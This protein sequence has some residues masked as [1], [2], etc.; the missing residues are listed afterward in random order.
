MANRS[1]FMNDFDTCRFQR[2][3]VWLGAAS[4]G[5]DDLDSAL[6]DRCDVFRIR[7]RR[8]H[9]KKSQVHAEWSVSHVATAGNFLGQ[10]LG[11]VLRQPSDD[12]QTAGIGNRRCKFGKTD[13]VHAALD[14][15]MPY[16]E[17]FGNGCPHESLQMSCP[18]IVRPSTLSPG[19]A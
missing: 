5:F 4:S 9:R 3:Q 2:R 12:A 8:K 6:N 1:A 18:A 19:W 7:R 14:D 13:I 17:Q 15:R 16:P 11:G 10:Q